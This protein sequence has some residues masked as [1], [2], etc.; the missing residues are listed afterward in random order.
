MSRNYIGA[1]RKRTNTPAQN[2]KR[3]V[4]YRH[5][6]YAT[7]KIE[8][9]PVIEP[10]LILNDAEEPEVPEVP[11]EVIEEPE[12]PEVISQNEETAAEEPEKLTV[13]EAAETAAAVGFFAKL[14]SSFRNLFSRKKNAEDESHTVVSDLKTWISSPIDPDEETETAEPLETE[15]EPEE[16]IA[17][18]ETEVTESV[19]EVTASE[20]SEDIFAET[21]EPASAEPETAE[22][23][24]EE[25]ETSENIEEPEVLDEETGKPQ[26]ETSEPAEEGEPEEQIEE[27]SEPSEEP[28]PVEEPV[29]TEEHVSAEELTETEEPET[30]G[31]EI[32][33]EALNEEG[34]PEEPGEDALILPEEEPQEET[35]ETAE[36]GE[37]EEQSEEESEPA[38]EPEE[39][40]E[41]KAE[42]I[43]PEEEAEPA[44]TSE[45]PQ[46]EEETTE[47]PQEAEEEPQEEPEP[48]VQP[49]EEETPLS[50]K[51]K[52]ELKKAI[53]KETKTQLIDEIIDSPR[54]G[55][56]VMLLAPGAAMKRVSTV[57]K[58]TLSAPSV[59]IL[60]FMKWAA[61]GT[62]FA[63]FIEKFINHFNYS[64]I[65]MN[66]TGTAT[67]AFR[68]GVF[69]LIAEYL[70]WMVIGLFCG[71]IRRKV[72]TLKLMEVEARS[73]LFVTL[74]FVIA[75]LLVSKDMF[76]YGVAVGICGM[77]AGLMT[78]GY[79]MDLVLPIGKNTQLILV[80]ILV[81]AAMLGA[82]KY[83]PLTVSGLM[84]IFKAI[85]N[86]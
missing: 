39:I 77:V 48:E 21:E 50:R 42:E 62:F 14:G 22:E 76:G 59:F 36:E 28:E 8:P 65:R 40:T 46:P 58:T 55:L 57:E 49:E 54:A 32:S 67:M 24:I 9:E 78:K 53:R 52:R 2:R 34:E 56:L 5:R 16:I 23:I 44:E 61:V 43:I 19:E 47:E 66:F 7:L 60:N 38:E 74:L 26:E 20:E 83:F 4:E 85:L 68:F 15:T 31:E 51:E 35:S 81:F 70:C 69:G 71:L 75:A 10:E 29:E 37:P 17:A 27:V 13:A 80:V 82:Y 73:A 45:E 30:S 64:F 79:G 86:L 72:S 63:L 84:D 6:P 11:E 1:K 41:E 33:E 3:A 18:E 25:A 12:Q